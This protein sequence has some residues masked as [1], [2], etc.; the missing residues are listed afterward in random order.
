MNVNILADMTNGSEITLNKPRLATMKGA[1][2]NLSG[3]M[4]ETVRI[5]TDHMFFIFFGVN[6]HKYDGED[7]K[8]RN[9]NQPRSSARKGSPSAT[10]KGT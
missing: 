7:A 9:D 4:T 1:S 6:E 2:S 8:S 5:R 3:N 10:S